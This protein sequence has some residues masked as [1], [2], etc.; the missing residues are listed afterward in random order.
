MAV[1]FFSPLQAGAPHVEYAR[2]GSGEVLRA[3]ATPVDVSI[4]CR[5]YR[6]VANL[7]GL[8]PDTRYQYRVGL[9]NTTLGSPHGFRTAPAGARPFTFLAVA[10]MGTSPNASTTVVTMANQTFDFVLQVGDISYAGANQTNWSRWFDLVQP[11]AAEHPYMV[12]P[13]N[14]ENGSAKEN[15]YFLER[16]SMPPGNPLDRNRTGMYYS[17]N[18]SLGHFVALKADFSKQED[19]D[20]RFREHLPTDPNWDPLE[21]E[22]LRRDLEAAA[23]D[24][25]HPWI[26]VYFHMPLFTSTNA[27]ASWFIARQVWG[28]LFD[29]YHVDLVI[30]AH[31]HNYERTYPVWSNGTAVRGR[32]RSLFRD[33]PAPI[34]LVTGG[35]GEKLQPA[36]PPENWT[37]KRSRTFEF[38]RVAVNGSR[39]NVSALWSANGTA[40]DSFTILRPNV[41][42]GSAEGSSAP[43]TPRLEASR[44]RTRPVPTPSTSG[45]PM[46]TEARSSRR[47]PSPPPRPS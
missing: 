17:F 5:E 45:S 31:K 36:G 6:Y 26:V 29:R 20:G 1:S 13:G 4:S 35:G 8:Q 18:Y 42:V 44:A 32:T 39:M 3:D 37:A 34:Y 30:N 15:S 23:N 9:N 46:A 24:T 27:T 41:T 16:F 21:T 7:V 10:D 38:L 47:G 12:V 28:S 25:V 43:V 2:N 33:P 11:I 40:L 19:T 14:H 22:W